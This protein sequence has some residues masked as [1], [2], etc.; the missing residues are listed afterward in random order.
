MHKK[1]VLY[2][3]DSVAS[4]IEKLLK[5][6]SPKKIF[7]VTGNNSYKESGAEEYFSNIFKKNS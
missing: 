7:L 1:Q 5:K 3:G 6:D 4:D 2:S